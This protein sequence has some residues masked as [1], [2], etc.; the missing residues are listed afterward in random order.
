MNSTKKPIQPSIN[1]IEKLRD[2]LLTS[3]E[4]L[5]NRKIDIDE[6][7]IIAKSG[8]AIMSSLKL[9]LTYANMLGHVPNVRFLEDC[10][11]GTPLPVIDSVKKQIES[12]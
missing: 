4:K 3:L 1:N 12:Q 2:H 6:V 7:S 8:E 9:Q 5:E 11:H 10:H